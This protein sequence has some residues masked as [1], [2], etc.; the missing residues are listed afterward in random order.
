MCFFHDTHCNTMKSKQS[1]TQNPLRPSYATLQAFFFPTEMKSW[2][3][4]R[5]KKK[6]KKKKNQASF[7]DVLLL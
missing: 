3:R 4:K 2:V 7:K 5:K 6:K 1:W